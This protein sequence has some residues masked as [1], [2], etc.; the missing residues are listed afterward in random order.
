MPL[1]IRCRRRA[2]AQPS[3]SGDAGE[4][5]TQRM[6]GHHTLVLTASGLQKTGVRVGWDANQLW[7]EPVRRLLQQ[8]PQISGCQLG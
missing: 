5:V 6:W 1:V 8:N 3:S 2:T 7:V 4:G